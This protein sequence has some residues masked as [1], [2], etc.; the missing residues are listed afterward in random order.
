MTEVVVQRKLAQAQISEFYHDLFVDTQVSHFEALCTPLPVQG[1]L[2]VVDIGGGCGFFASAV[3]KRVGL[4]TR[5]I[6]MDAASVEQCRQNGIEAMVGDALK[7]PIFGDEAVIC[8]NLILH[9]LVGANEAAT[10]QLQGGALGV[11]QG[12]PI[13][14]FVNEYIYD[15]YVGNLSG[16]MIYAVTSSRVLS[17]LAN[18]VTKIV[19]SLKANTFGVGVRFRSAAEWVEF[20]EMRDWRVVEHIRGEEEIVSPARRCLLIKSCRRDSFVLQAIGSSEVKYP[21]DSHVN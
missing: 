20:F 11:W 16:K 13:R 9:H 15:S 1:P 5:V 7:P 17:Y 3:T 19:P 2:C 4:P 14:V 21:Y 6:D 8:F 18:W 10:Q 12:K